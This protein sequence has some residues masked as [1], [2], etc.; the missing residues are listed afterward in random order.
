MGRK[1]EMDNKIATMDKL[2]HRW[3][4]LRV[5]ETE[6][7]RQ[8]WQRW[9][10]P[11]R[12]TLPVFLVGCG[13]SGT[14]M[15]VRYLG[16]SWWLEFYNE[17]NPAAFERWRLRD[18]SAIEALID[19]SYAHVTL[20]KPIL[21][22]YQTPILLA[23]FPTAKAIFAFRHYDDVINS[24]IKRFGIANRLKHVRAW[25]EE[26]FNEFAAVPP[27]EETKIFIREKWKPSLSPESGA[28]LYWL[29]QNRLYF[30]LG[31]YQSKRVKLVQY[32]SIV[33]RPAEEF[34]SLCGFLGIPFEP[35]LAAGI[36]SSSIGRNSPPTIDPEIRAA[37]EELWQRLCG[38]AAVWH[39]GTE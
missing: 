28:A 8:L 9:Q 11:A 17:D 30:D 23:R 24:S 12:E 29:F 18:L 7:R 26:D 38:T 6:L 27:P 15:I 19:R 21:D 36:F 34:K 37:C 33:S 4:G 39:I 22:T 16:K 32:E 35:Q 2:R 10:N 3:Y 1:Q 13:R 25:I 20:F 5:A 14:S 31:L